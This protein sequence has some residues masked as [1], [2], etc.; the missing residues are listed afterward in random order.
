[1][2]GPISD[3]IELAPKVVWIWKL[4]A[5]QTHNAQLEPERATRRDCVS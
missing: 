5:Q 4:A 1:M 2:M 3:I